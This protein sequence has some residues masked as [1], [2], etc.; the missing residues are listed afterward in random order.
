MSNVTS[1]RVFCKIKKYIIII[2]IHKIMGI[3]TLK[4]SE[5]NAVFCFV[6]CDGS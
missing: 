1:G 3:C 5:E 6:R 2:I 4:K